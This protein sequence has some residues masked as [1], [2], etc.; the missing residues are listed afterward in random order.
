MLIRGMT[1]KS[2]KTRFEVNTVLQILNQLNNQRCFSLHLLQ[3]E[4]AEMMKNYVINIDSVRNRDLPQEFESLAKDNSFRGYKLDS[5]LHRKVKAIYEAHSKRSDTVETP[6]KKAF[7]KM[8]STSSVQELPALASGTK[9]KSQYSAKDTLIGC[10]NS[11]NTLVGPTVKRVNS[12]LKGLMNKDIDNQRLQ[13]KF[14][15]SAVASFYREEFAVDSQITRAN[16]KNSVSKVSKSD[17]KQNGLYFSKSKHLANEANTYGSNVPHSKSKDVNLRDKKGISMMGFNIFKANIGK[18][19]EV[20]IGSKLTVNARSI[21]KQ[22]R[23]LEFTPFLHE[24]LRTK[25][26]P[27]SK[28][29]LLRFNDVSKT[30]YSKQAI[31]PSVANKKSDEK[32]SKLQQ[33]KDKERE[34]QEKNS[35]LRN[36]IDEKIKAI[37]V[38]DWKWKGLDRKKVGLDSRYLIKT[39]NN[40][41]A[42][43]LHASQQ[44]HF[45]YKSSER[46]TA[47]PK[48]TALKELTK[49]E[50][51]NNEREYKPFSFRKVTVKT[52]KGKVGLLRKLGS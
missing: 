30:E 12:D 42:P 52:E 15:E 5:V 38:K 4:Y 34:F 39:Q 2:D 8:C 18:K 24:T 20:E 40:Q 1:D 13:S 6:E 7:E 10:N 21:D 46:L 3:G 17:S 33:I 23:P 14:S 22:K 9:P 49:T 41:T 51:D 43:R 35:K 45:D 27:L 50:T 36:K 19:S 31:A 26:T 48:K 11:K 37:F 25:D 32:L 29:S 28:Y 47:Y 16:K 44:L